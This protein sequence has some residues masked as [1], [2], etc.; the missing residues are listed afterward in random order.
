MMVTSVRS[1]SKTKRV[2]SNVNENTMSWFRAS[3]DVINKENYDFAMCFIA[4]MLIN[5]LNTN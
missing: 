1:V 2:V 3:V 4:V 5:Y